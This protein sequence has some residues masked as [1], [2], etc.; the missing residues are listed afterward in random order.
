MRQEMLSSNRQS[1]PM[2]GT[3]SMP[4]TVLLSE[5]AKM[6]NNKL[7][8]VHWQWRILETHLAANDLQGLLKYITATTEPTVYSQFF[9]FLKC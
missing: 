5:D 8:E 2:L 9:F 7:C 1:A 6:D 4:H 3:H